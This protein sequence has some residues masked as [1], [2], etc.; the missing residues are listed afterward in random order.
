MLQQYHPSVSPAD[1]QAFIACQ[2]ASLSAAIEERA[3]AGIG[4]HLDG[5]TCDANGG[6]GGGCHFD[7]VNGGANG[8]GGGGRHNGGGS[9]SGTD[10]G[11]GVDGAHY[12]G[13]ATF[14]TFKGAGTASM[15]AGGTIDTVVKKSAITRSGEVVVVGVLSVKK[16]RSSRFQKQR[17]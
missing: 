15:S 5:G 7:G 8:D 1:A 10:V 4:G 13:G 12:G 2:W 14:P 17:R 11:G 16:H 3:S 6:D 9:V